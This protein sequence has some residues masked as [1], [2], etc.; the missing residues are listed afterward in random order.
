MG[1]KAQGN[2]IHV[3]PIS[4]GA[5]S[6][7]GEAAV[8]DIGTAME[9]GT[10]LGHASSLQRGQ[11]VP[12][13]KNFHGSPAVETNANYCK[14]EPRGCTALRRWL[15][16][17]LP[18]VPAIFIG[19]AILAIILK[20]APYLWNLAA[21]A[22]GGAAPSVTPPMAT[23]AVLGLVT[24]ILSL[25]AIGTGLASVILI[26]RLLSRL[27]PRD[28]TYVLYGWRY[29][30]F[31]LIGALSNVRFYNLIFGDSSAIVHYLQWIG[32]NLNKVEQT[33][34]NFGTNQKHD[35]P[36]LCEIGSG[37]MV[38]DGLSMMNAS[39]SATSFR[40]SHTKIGDHNYLGNNIHYPWDGNT[41]V[42]VLLGTK[43]MIPIDGPVREN[44][45]LLG[46]PPFEIPRAVS[47]DLELSGA[48]NATRETRIQAKNWH[49][50][51]TIVA[52]LLSGWLFLFVTTLF[53][54]AAVAAYPRGGVVSLA[55]F[56]VSTLFTGILFFAFMERASLGFKPLQPRTVPVLDHYFW[57]HER[58]WKFCEL[59]LQSMF[60]GTPFKNV[61][62]RLLGVKVGRKTFDDGAQFLEKTLIT[63]GDYANLNEAVTIQGHSLEEGVFKSDYI[64]VGNGCSLGTGAF[65]H[66]GVR[67]G[68]DVVIDP[69]SFLMK[70]EVP[71]AGTIWQGNP[72]KAIRRAVE[73]LAR[74]S[75]TG[76]AGVLEEAARGGR[77]AGPLAA[78]VGA[79]RR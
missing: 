74:S 6:F 43:V 79:N 9:D 76:P 8:L 49:N 10:Q 73:R 61:I 55:L 71:D 31:R 48:L 13:G 21:E 2:M 15:Y 45:G 66:Y 36:F 28:E 38:S 57:D 50:L 60:K 11:R 40:L 7:V 4:I 17:L 52:W 12:A 34:S 3:A 59:P 37:T 30:V 47:R 72:A 1:Y 70:G 24:F 62:S 16:A 68:D 42:N 51:V 23:S 20:F 39:M 14:I 65:I 44:I 46:S 63:I 67:I 25:V 58:H 78:R 54:Y 22:S 69:D 19:P 5:N 27:V 26:P 64:V 35:I 29:F 18:V 33:G 77:H 32:W 53:G 56:S 41:G 75:A